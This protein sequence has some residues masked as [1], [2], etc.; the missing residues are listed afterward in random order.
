MSRSSTCALGVLWMVDLLASCYFASLPPGRTLRGARNPPEDDPLAAADRPTSGDGQATMPATDQ[1]GA[2]KDSTDKPVQGQSQ[3]QARAGIRP[4]DRRRMAENPHRSTV[5][6]SRG[7]RRRS[8]RF[9]ASTRPAISGECFVCVCCDA[10]LFSTL[11]TSSIPERD[12]P[13]LIGPRTPGPSDREMDYGA[14][15]P[16]VEVM[17]RRCGAHLGHVFDDG[18]TITGLRF[19]INSAADQAQASRR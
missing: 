10:E 12:G 6:W 4:Q 17:C 15:E 1:D 11:R 8:P 13:A 5:S 9:P 19:C 16:R 18:P 7:R 3:G 2:G 14:F